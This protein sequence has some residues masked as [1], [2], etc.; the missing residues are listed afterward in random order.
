MA[1][2]TRSARRAKK[3][4]CMDVIQKHFC[5]CKSFEKQFKKI[6]SILD[7]MQVELEEQKQNK[8]V[9]VKR[10][11]NGKSKEQIQAIIEA[12]QAEL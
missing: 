4:I 10:L 6:E 5:E 11:V 12:L 9:S 8:K 1:K 7:I 3:Q 2:Q